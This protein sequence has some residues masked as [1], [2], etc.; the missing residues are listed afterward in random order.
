MSAGFFLWGMV[1]VCLVLS[2][3]IKTSKAL[4]KISNKWGKLFRD[5]AQIGALAAG[6]WA[7]LFAPMPFGWPPIREIV[8]NIVA[9][10]VG[11]FYAGDATSLVQIIGGAL[12]ACA[13]IVFVK[14]VSDGQMDGKAKTALLASPILTALAAGSWVES[15]FTRMH[16]FFLT[17]VPGFFQAIGHG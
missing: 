2:T 7:L 9:T 17:D 14:D 4:G 5:A 13:L 12:L 11:W 10:V 6:V 1:L 3:A 16:A 8:A 15:L